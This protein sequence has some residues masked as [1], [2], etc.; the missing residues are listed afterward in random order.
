MVVAV[1]ILIANLF[2]L[3]VLH[4]EYKSSGSL[5]ARKFLGS[6]LPSYARSHQEVIALSEDYK[7]SINRMTLLSVVLNG[8]FFLVN[9]IGIGFFMLYYCVWLF[10]CIFGYQYLYTRSLRRLFA[11]KKEHGWF[12]EQNLT[13]YTPKDGSEPF[14]ADD[15]QFWLKGWYEN[16]E[17][18]HVLA[19]QKIPAMNMGF[20]L[21]NK[22]GRFWN[23]VTLGGTAALLL[24]MVVWFLMMDFK[25]FTMEIQENTVIV[26]AA[27]YGATFEIGEIENLELLETF[28][29]VAMSRTNGA[30]TDGYLLGKFDMK[31]IGKCRLFY[32]K[33]YAPIIRI[34]TEEYTVFFN[35]KD[36]EKTTALYEELEAKW[37]H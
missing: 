5:T 32:Y 29:N 30:A 25:P 2:V 33:G 22:K 19:P 18:V 4:A 3:L 15:D 11:L 21:G 6:E 27:G 17:D 9:V 13:L 36:A 24:W 26:D 10:G 1:I 16:P 37:A 12:D 20:N 28:P 31:G 35:T 14:L 8:P 7:K 23:F 34:E